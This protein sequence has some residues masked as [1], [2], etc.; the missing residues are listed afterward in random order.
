MPRPVTGGRAGRPAKPAEVKRVLGNP[1]K[2]PLPNAPTPGTAL[3]VAGDTPVAP[4]GLEGKGLESWN[5]LWDAGKAHLSARA[6]YVLMEQLCWAL[7][8][9]DEL[10]RW[11]AEDRMNRSWYTTAN[12]QTVTHPSVKRVE[13]LDAQTTSWLAQL[14]FTPSDR[15]RLGLLEVR[16]PDELDDFRRRLGGRA[17]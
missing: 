7:G 15:A 6:D 4:P 17:G 9:K 1:G 14:G 2:R 16:T 3:E 10:R 11:L 12:G 5:R 8:E 13:Q